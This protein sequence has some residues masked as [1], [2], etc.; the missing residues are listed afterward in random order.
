MCCSPTACSPSSC[1]PSSCSRLLQA[2][3]FSQQHTA[4]QLRKRRKTREAV[5]ANKQNRGSSTFA[6]RDTQRHTETERH[7]D[8]QT[9]RRR[10]DATPL[11]SRVAMVWCLFVVVMAPISGQYHR[12]ISHYFPK[13][14]GWLLLLLLGMRLRRLS[15]WLSSVTV[16]ARHLSSTNRVPF[17]SPGLVSVLVCGCMCLCV[18]VRVCLCVAVC[19]CVCVCLCEGTDV[20]ARSHELCCSLFLPPP[21]CFCGQRP[22]KHGPFFV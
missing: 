11:S 15:F 21:S 2:R 4:R 18:R 3:L 1:S 6:D 13:Q 10:R 12:S 8:T 14:E 7:T 19:V 5:C 20:H 17:P 9:L 22:W 16:S